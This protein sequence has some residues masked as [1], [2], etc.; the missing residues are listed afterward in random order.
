M[1]LRVCIAISRPALVDIQ[2]PLNI[3]YEGNQQAIDDIPAIPL[4]LRKHIQ[5]AAVVIIDRVEFKSKTTVGG[6]NNAGRKAFPDRLE[7]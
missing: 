5:D 3:R 1:F 6:S 7:I 4:R 2:I